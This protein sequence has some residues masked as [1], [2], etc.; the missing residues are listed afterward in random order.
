M[1]DMGSWTPTWG[2]KGKGGAPPGA[3]QPAMESNNLFV[4]DLPSMMDEAQ[5]SSVLGAYGQIQDLKLLPPAASGKRAALIRFSST[6]EAK[7]IVENLNGNIPQGFT[8]PI[9]VKYKAPPQGKGC[10]KDFGKDFGGGCGGGFDGFSKGFKD[11]GF[12]K[13]C[14]GKGK[15]GPIGIKQLVDGI[16]ESGALPGGA[17]YTNDENTLFVGGMPEDTTDEDL[18]LLFS[19]FG[20]IAPRG[21]RAMAN[22]DKSACKGFGFVN[23]LDYASSATAIE[24]LNGTQYDGKTLKVCRKKDGGPGKGGGCGGCGGKGW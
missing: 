7:W 15:S 21:V 12:G 5:L 3:E 16:L 1:G 20:A 23:F 11:K 10:G 13:G 22:E 2:G 17:K 24:T 8:E 19:P 4:G 18:F 9:T 6:A 14:K